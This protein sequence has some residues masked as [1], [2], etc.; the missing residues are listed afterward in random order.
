MARRL[1]F[2]LGRL[3][4]AIGVLMLL[5]SHIFTSWKLKQAREDVDRMAT[6]L[7]RLTIREPDRLNVVAVP[8][9]DDLTW[10]WRA[11][12]PEARK[13]Y[14]D[15]ATAEIPEIGVPLHPHKGIRFSLPAGEFMLTVAARR[16]RV[17]E[18]KL[19]VAEQHHSSVS[20]PIPEDHAGWLVDNP[21]YIMT[22]QAGTD[23]TESAT[24][25]EHLVLL[26]VTCG[27]TAT[28]NTPPASS[29]GL[30][31]W[32]VEERPEPSPAVSTSE[33][34]AAEAYEPPSRFP[35]PVVEPESGE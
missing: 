13:Y 18:W 4:L 19:T 20:T 6:E 14:L 34:G 24:D 29:S 17:G 21:G 8:T 23:G 31:V 33:G 10:R 22:S 35:E 26:R 16:D 7:G 25:G 28:P 30:M 15:W 32:A 27:T 9:Y 2:S 5:G 11:H 1:Q 12:V 3:L